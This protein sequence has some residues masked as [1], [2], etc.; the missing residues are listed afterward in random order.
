MCR[1]CLVLKRTAINMV[2]LR[3]SDK[4]YKIAKAIL[5]K[6]GVKVNPPKADKK[7]NVKSPYLQH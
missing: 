5:N 7:L 3:P 6:K 1:K 2:M 4:A